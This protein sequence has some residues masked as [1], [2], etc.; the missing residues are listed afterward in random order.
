M[1]IIK[2][3]QYRNFAF[4]NYFKLQ[5]IQNNLKRINLKR[6]WISIIIT[7]RKISLW[8]LRLLPNA[9]HTSPAYCTTVSSSQ[10]GWFLIT[11]NNSIYKISKNGVVDVPVTQIPM[12]FCTLWSILK[13]IEDPYLYSPMRTDNS[14]TR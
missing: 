1:I 12:H 7:I 8:E 2:K 13:Q 9:T 6:E 11:E 4:L 10:N 3:I 14:I 5:N